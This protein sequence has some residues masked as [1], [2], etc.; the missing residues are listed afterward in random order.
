MDH[1][2]VLQKTDRC[3]MCGLCLPHCPTY[4]KTRDEG[5][6]PRGR[7]ALMQGLFSGR[8]EL[9]EPLEAHLDH[10][11]A[12]RACEAVCPSGV[13]YGELIDAARAEI[14][15]RRPR[16]A[17]RRLPRRTAKAAIVH[18]PLLRAAAIL[19]RAYRATGLQRLARQTGLLRGTA[20]PALDRL[21]DS[22]PIPRPWK[23]RYLAK[24]SE[25]GQV[26]LFT[27]CV[28]DAM[29]QTT[30]RSA[31]EVLTRLGFSVWVPRNQTCC[32]A[33][34]LHAGDPE[35]ARA[36]ARRNI[37][38]FAPAQAEAVLFAASGCGAQL[39]EY[40]RL[41]DGE[42][43]ATQF[44]RRAR[45]IIPFLNDLEWPETVRLAPLQARV[46]IHEP[47]S[48]THVL[49]QPGQTRTLLGRIPGIELVPLPENGR[50]CGAAGSYMISQPEMA[51]ALLD[52][53]LEHLKRL[54]P[55]ILVT[56]NV[57]CALHFQAGIR[58]A[59][60]EIE[61]LHPVTLIARQMTDN[62]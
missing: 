45:D 37:A 44:S 6:S 56:S 40:S 2:S 25:R 46:A 31:I 33:V 58:A 20:L 32:G 62:A 8:L 11:L 10:C 16:S 26:A 48:V 19:A 42:D 36:L 49:R 1:R 47:C 13:P 17:V 57:G 14:E 43:E 15:S 53:K 23:R 35:R 50:C 28:T 39:A 24:S 61:V 18:K 38:A 52:D 59:G 55:S 41:L 5:E 34:H 21:A 22:F 3:V 51:Q 4:I 54:A 27:G 12:C 9:T 60:L 30:L 7:I 29:D